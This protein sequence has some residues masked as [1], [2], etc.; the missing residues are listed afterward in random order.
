M[1]TDNAKIPNSRLAAARLVAD[2]L[3][4]AEFP[5]RLMESVAA[6]RGFIMEL[7]YGIIRRHRALEWIRSQLVERKPQTE[8]EAVLLV[9][10]YQLCFMD[11][12]AE[13]AAINE[14]V[15]A[16]KA[17]LKQKAANMVNAVLRHAQARKPAL[18]KSLASQPDGARLSHPD[19]L[20]DRWKKQ[21]GVVAAIRLCEWNN[22]RPDMTV[23]VNAARISMP[24][25]QTALK[26][27]GM[28]G[29]PHPFAPQDFLVLP[30]G[31]RVNDL[32]GFAEG[33]F[34]V[35]DPSTQLAV[36]LLD[37]HPGERILDAC[38]APGGKTM[39]IAE[40][41]KGE[42]KLVASDPSEDRLK[43]LRENVARLGWNFIEVLKS[44]MATDTFNAILLDVPCSNTG[45]IRRRPDARWRFSLK[46]LKQVCDQQVAILDAAAGRLEPGGRLVYSTCSL[47]PEEDEQQIATWLARHPDFQ[48]IE[49]RRLFPPDSGTDGVYAALIRKEAA[50][51]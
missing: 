49:Q 28:D 1:K 50:L 41:M 13:Y 12:V 38:A 17:E 3:K 20:L 31:L 51:E 16:A 23:R 40:R 37:P 47:E 43:R 39:I 24:D 18:M 42:G 32:P 19:L 35:Q 48:L 7:V 36:D 27:A 11:N 9:G 21:F 22:S 10:L 45:V 29:Q 2:W 26:K 44:G 46:D 33:W 8:L 4:T 14:T 15:E 6:D 25:W 30:H 34:F 5:D